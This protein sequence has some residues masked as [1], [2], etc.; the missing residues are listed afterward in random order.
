MIDPMM[1]AIPARK[2]MRPTTRPA[3][4]MFSAKPVSEIAFGVSRD[5]ISRLRISS[6]VGPFRGGRGRRGAPFLRAP[7]RWVCSGI[8]TR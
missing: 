1:N 2:N 3:A 7:G 4:A 6:A 8:V 5:S